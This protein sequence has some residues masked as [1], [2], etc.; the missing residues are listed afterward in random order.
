MTR[1]GEC[2]GIHYLKPIHSSRAP[3][4]F[5]GEVVLGVDRVHILDRHP[6]LD[7]AQRK[8][9]RSVLLVFEN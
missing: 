3:V 9:S 2:Y 1:Q 7:A 6:A 4:A 5:K 8:S